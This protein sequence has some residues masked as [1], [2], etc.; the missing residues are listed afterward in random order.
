MIIFASVDFP[1]PLFPFIKTTSPRENLISS[2]RGG[3]VDCSLEGQNLL[4]I[5]MS[6]FLNSGTSCCNPFSVSESEWIVF[7]TLLY[8][9]RVYYLHIRYNRTIIIKMFD[10][11]EFH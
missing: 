10:Y 4:D 8:P 2:S 9:I 3:N 5:V 7:C 6:K 1:V 11:V